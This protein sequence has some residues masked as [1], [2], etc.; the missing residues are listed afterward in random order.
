MRLEN[1]T[2]MFTSNAG[3]Y[4]A[5]KED[6][7]N[8]T[9]RLLDRTEYRTLRKYKPKRIRI[10]KRDTQGREYFERSLR[11]T[12]DINTLLGMRL[13]GFTWNAA[14]IQQEIQRLF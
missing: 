8:W 6:L 10:M 13:V 5:E 9:I 4:E 3:S 11:D 14:S 12:R 2:V 1:G 7:K